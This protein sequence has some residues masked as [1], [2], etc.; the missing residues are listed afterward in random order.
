M[1]IR[2]NTAA[3]NAQLD[4]TIN[5]A[6]DSGV[7][8]IRTGSQ[9]TTADDEATGTLLCELE[10]AADAFA[11]ADGGVIAKQ[12]TWE[13]QNVASGT[14]GWF[15]LRSDD[16]SVRIDGAI[17]TDLTVTG[18]TEGEMIEGGTSQVT[19]LTITAPANA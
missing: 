19:S 11:A 10:V 6:F 3:R 5:T 1:A 18:P 4:G 17:P 13:G 7:L 8:E 16:D 2:L 9:P 14:P 12:G 15:R